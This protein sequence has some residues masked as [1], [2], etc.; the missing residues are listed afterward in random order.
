MLQIPVPCLPMQ[1]MC[2]PKKQ[3]TNTTHYSY[4]PYIGHSLPPPT[5]KLYRM[6]SA[7]P[8]EHNT[9]VG[10]GRPPAPPLQKPITSVLAAGHIH[11]VQT[12]SH[13]LDWSWTSVNAQS[14]IHT[15]INTFARACTWVFKKKFKLLTRGQ[16]PHVNISNKTFMHFQ[17]F[18][19]FK[20]AYCVWVSSSLISCILHVDMPRLARASRCAVHICTYAES[21]ELQ[22]VELAN[23]FSVDWTHYMK[24]KEQ[25]IKKLTMVFRERSCC[26]LQAWWRRGSPRG[27]GCNSR[28]AETSP[29]GWVPWLGWGNFW[30]HF[31]RSTC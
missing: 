15:R 6:F 24:T 1:P 20:C 16:Q 18:W 8:Q 21:V 2:G 11:T 3:K 31:C 10:I 27:S 23:F 25:S 17:D 13:G 14:S 7:V 19:F 26:Y 4:S 12:P 22:P 30:L 29:S 28:V 5:L 9:E